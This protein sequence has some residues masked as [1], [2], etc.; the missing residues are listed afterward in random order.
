MKIYKARTLKDIRNP[1][2]R[3]QRL[4]DAVDTLIIRIDALNGFN[5]ENH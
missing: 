4:S 2:Y 3:I 5:D 1:V